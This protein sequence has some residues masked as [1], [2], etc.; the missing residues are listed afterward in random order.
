MQ[1]PPR[2]VPGAYNAVPGTQQ[3]PPSLSEGPHLVG[4]IRHRDIDLDVGNFLTPSVP[5]LPEERPQLWPGATPALPPERKLQR[6]LG[7]I[8]TGPMMEH[9]W[10]PPSNASSAGQLK[11][12]PAQCE[13]R[14]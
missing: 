12:W 9:H 5:H 13:A 10:Q 1:G 11:L 14:V 8:Y 3:G 7:R 2:L 4:A 6:R